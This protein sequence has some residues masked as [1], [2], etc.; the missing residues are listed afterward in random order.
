MRT[1]GLLQGKGPREVE[2]EAGDR[3]LVLTLLTKKRQQEIHVPAAT[4]M[5]EN[6]MARQEVC[7]L[8]EAFVSA[9]SGLVLSLPCFA[10]EGVP[11]SLARL[12]D[13]ALPC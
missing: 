3:R 10:L 5:A 1:Q 7:W 8:Y 11:P 13:D 9:S 6:M 4:G 2:N 12:A